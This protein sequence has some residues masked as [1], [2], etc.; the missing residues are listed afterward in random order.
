MRGRKAY[1]AVFFAIDWRFDLV[2]CFLDTRVDLDTF[3]KYLSAGNKTYRKATAEELFT[4]LVEVV[5]MQNL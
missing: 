2:S 3:V 4:G 1:Y 5:T